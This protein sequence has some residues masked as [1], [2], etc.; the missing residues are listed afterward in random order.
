MEQEFG[1][2]D[3]AD[4]LSASGSGAPPREAIDGDAA[5][6]AP[7][8]SPDGP[9]PSPFDEQAAAIVS[10]IGDGG[11]SF[12]D[13]ATRLLTLVLDTFHAVGTTFLRTVQDTGLLVPCGRPVF[14]QEPGLHKSR[15]AGA[16]N[17]AGD[18]AAGSFIS[19][20]LRRGSLDPAFASA[21][22]IFMR[23]T[24]GPS[25]YTLY[26]LPVV[27]SGLA[28]ASTPAGSAPATA[29]LSGVWVIMM[30]AFPAGGSRASLEGRV[31]KVHVYWRLLMRQLE[32]QE[33]ADA[34]LRS[35]T[36]RLREVA[37]IYEIG[38]AVDRTEIE[39]LFHMITMKAASVMEA[40]ACSLLL[41]DTIGDQLTIAASYGLADE[42]VENTR[43]FVGEGI[44]GRVAQ[45]GEPL[46]VN[47][48]VRTDPRFSDAPM[49]GLPGISSSISMPMKDEW[50]TV[51]GVLCIRRRTPAPPFSAD[52]ERLFGVFASQASMAIKNARLYRQLRSRVNELSTLSSLAEA[53]SS[54]LDLN[55]VLNQLAEDIL[56]VVGFD[57]CL[58]YLRAD[59]DVDGG[60]GHPHIARGFDQLHEMD[61]DGAESSAA[62]VI[63]AVAREQNPLLVGDLESAAPAAQSYAQTLGITSFFAHPIIVSG[64]TIGVVVVTTDVTGR[65][66]ERANSDLLITFLQ[67]AG[68]AIENARLYKQMEMRVHELN[69]LYAMSRS[70]STTFRFDRSCETVRKVACD[71]SRSDLSMLLLFNQRMDSLRVQSHQGAD[72]ALVDQL[73]VLPDTMEISR[74]ARMLREP[75]PFAPGQASLGQ[76]LFGSAWDNCLQLASQIYP[77]QLLV[78]L[79]TEESNVGFLL[80]GR[81]E[82]TA[83]DQAT[84]NLVSIIASQAAAVLRSAALYEYSI[85]QR[86]LELSALYELSKKVRSARSITDACDAIVDI[87][88]SVVLCDAAFLYLVDKDLNSMRVQ[89]WFGDPPDRVV[90]ENLSSSPSMAAWVVRERK[91]FLSADIKSDPRFSASDWGPSTRSLMVI[92]IFMADESLGV[93]QVQSYSRNLYSEDN[94]KM[95]SL[96][97]AQ[98]AALYREMRTLRELTTYTDN[99]LYSIEAGVVTLDASGRIVTFNHAAERILRLSQRQA[100]GKPVEEMVRDLDATPDDYADTLKLVSMA[101]ATGG[102]VQRHRL[103]YYSSNSGKATSGIHASDEVVVNGSASPLR[104]ERGDSL[105]VVLVFEDITKEQEMEQEIQRISRLAEI[106]QLA[107]GIAHELRNPLASIKGAAQV[108]KE[109]LSEEALEKHGEFLDIIVNEVNVLNGVTSEFL[110]FSRPLPPQ[111][112]PVQINELLARRIAFLRAEFE[113]NDVAVHEVYAPNLPELNVDSGMMDRVVTN[114]VLNAVQAMP[115]GGLFTVETRIEGD[116]PDQAIVLRFSDTGMGIEPDRV[117]S[118]FTPF[119]TTK[120]KGTGL[121]LAIVQKIIDTHGGRISVESAMEQGTTFVVWLPVSTPI[122]DR[123]PY[124][125]AQK[126]DISEQR[127]HAA[128]RPMPV[129]GR[130]DADLPGTDS[131]GQ[132]T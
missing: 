87:V 113:N 120:T 27:R 15:L 108:L 19:A 76:S 66:I 96:I 131:K 109:D 122:R 2:F 111:F 55:H 23:R 11:E 54:K 22:R 50:G 105:G 82:K 107:A 86:V 31:R 33:I 52:D 83:Y 61:G 45:T 13:A 125:A 121:G 88:K 28:A 25:G 102:A 62:G 114:I 4:D 7:A 10:S 85:E 1:Y 34:A 106:G 5:A 35:T 124:A 110:D 20:A 42:V 94:V 41:K 119:F 127:R 24:P 68:I 70:L 47:Y 71:I 9:G 74:E 81:R 101:L 44:A 95:L 91:A 104:S 29:M 132:S 75:V 103:R 89:A 18:A 80:L 57:R 26:S 115:D 123:T 92:P 97:A 78:P 73:R 112:S 36:K 93:L 69:T 63:A 117:P 32:L 67:H 30:P 21:R 59:G 128:K 43:I 8:A 118:I 130:L 17:R 126:H 77:R 12:A 16:M 6:P 39:G 37:T 51:M 72:P 65:P 38:K 46:L 100:L 56:N 90:V 84:R 48:D 99:I 53:I 40:Q 49:K 98:A 58:I 116:G 60:W 14:A 3:E 64:Q 129:A 79:V